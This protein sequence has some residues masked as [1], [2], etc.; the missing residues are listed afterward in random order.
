MVE[1]TINGKKISV[2]EGTTILEAALQNDIYIP[3]LCY[4][5][6]LTPYGAC[7][8]CIV[9]VEGQKKILASCSTPVTQGMIVHTETPKLLKARQTILE[10]LLIHHPLDCPICDKA[11]EC[12]LQDMAFKYGP[13]E[14]R[15]KAEKKHDLADTGSPLVER[16]PNRCILCGK[17]VRICGEFQGV[18]AINILGRGFKSKI[19]P[20]FEETLDCEFCGQCIDACPV[21]ALGSKPYKYRARA[22]FLEEHDN[23]CPYCSVGCTVTLDVREG[24]ILRARG[25]EGKGLNQGNLCGKGRFGFDYIYAENRLTMPLIKQDNE[26]KKVPWEKALA[27][28]AKNIHA[29]IKAHGAD[30]IGAIGSQRCTVEDNY[31]LQKLMRAVVGSNNIDSLARFGYAK[32]QKAVE[33][34]FGLKALPTQFNSPLGKEAILIIE[35]DIT[36]THPVWGLNFLKASRLFGTHLIVADTRKTKLTRHSSQWLRIKPAT[37]TALLNGIMKIALDEGLYDKEKAPSISGFAS[38]TEAVKDYS[39]ETVSR[40]TG[41]SEDAF[42]KAA[43]IFLSAKSKLIALTIGASE[44]TKGLNTALAAANLI[45]LIGESPSSLQMPAEYC[46][47]LGMWQMGI[48]P[49]MLPGYNSLDKKGFDAAA[50]L[51]SPGNI[52]ALYIMGENPVITFPDARKIEEVL[53]NLDFLVVQDITLTETAKL[54]HVVLPASSWSEKEGTFINAE[55]IAQKINKI[56]DSTDNAVPDWQILRNL[57]RVMGTDIG[58]KNIKALQDEIK[59]IKCEEGSTGIRFNPV[60]YTPAEETDVMY[61]IHMVTGNLMQHSGALSVMSKSLSSVFADAFLQVN[62]TDAEKYNIKDDSYI[63]LTSKRGSVFVKARISDE[64]PEGTVFVPIHFPH[65]RINSL[66]R[67][68]QNGDSPITAVRIE[69]AK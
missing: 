4:D 59:S 62:K 37:S 54:A 22:W 43:R 47:T 52:R 6:R 51:Y 10:L 65:A 40:I 58:A 66:T 34:A 30:S 46:N 32:I 39:P 15:F 44:D 25:V 64:I 55:G 33:M 7:R 57:A 28:I 49:D 1:L 21:G 42:I 27:Y 5:K 23:I 45:I 48:T 13:S 20:A 38:L 53:S 31:M 11:G 29:I 12:Q 50:M 56:T 61:P 2:G 3:N 41:L 63:K 68:S 36:S 8:M 24:K 16:N 19:S 69:A 67:L 14:S 26:F 35:S 18:G 9:E 17:C 60:V